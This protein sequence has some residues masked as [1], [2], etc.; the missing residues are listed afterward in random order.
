MRAATSARHRSSKLSRG[1]HG[2]A[3]AVADLQGLPDVGQ[4]ADR[5]GLLAVPIKTA[6]QSVRDP[7]IIGVRARTSFT[8]TAA[9]S[10]LE[11]ITD[12]EEVAFTC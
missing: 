2:G 5:L 1:R 12:T 11:E 7:G 8:P 9:L 6:S 3:A 4:G 10:C